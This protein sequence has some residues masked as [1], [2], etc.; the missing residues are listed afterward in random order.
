M[1]NLLF[2]I[3]LPFYTFCQNTIGLP[4]VIN[5][6]KQTYNA[7]LQNWHIKQ[8]QNGIIYVA[9]NEGLL[10]FDG[11]NWNLHSLPN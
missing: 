1:K 9:N 2:L 4:D 10:T 7:G 8:D 3:L 6:T 11:K 5:Y